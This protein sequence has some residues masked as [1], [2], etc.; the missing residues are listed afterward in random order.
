MIAI[1]LVH[2]S[3]FLMFVRGETLRLDYLVS[4]HPLGC[5]NT[6]V[7]PKGKV[8]CCFQTSPE[9]AEKLG[10]SE[11]L[12]IEMGGRMEREKISKH[13]ATGR[14]HDFMHAQSGTQHLHYTLPCRIM[15]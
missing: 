10:S 2:I 4:S 14:S 5:C 13:C 15:T 12:P 7:R 1:V 8:I 11:L 9:S 3:A 6:R